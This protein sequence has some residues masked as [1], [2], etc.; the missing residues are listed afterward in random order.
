MAKID[1]SKP[2]P[3]SWINVPLPPNELEPDFLGGV[4]HSTNLRDAALAITLT[5]VPHVLILGADIFNADIW[6]TSTSTEFF[7]FAKPDKPVSSPGPRMKEAH[8][9]GTATWNSVGQYALIAGGDF[10]L[11]GYER[12]PHVSRSTEIYRPNAVCS[13]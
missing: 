5:P 13:D 3:D 1:V 8:E 9:M 11:H 4:A 6:Q 7:D 10:H 12:I 2:R